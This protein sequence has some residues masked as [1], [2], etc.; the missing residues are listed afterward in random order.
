MKHLLVVGLLLCPSLLLAQADLTVSLPPGETALGDIGMYR[1]A[2]QSYDGQPVYMPDSWVGNFEPVAG[3]SY[4][5]GEKIMG[6]KALLLHSPWHIAPGRMWVDYRLKLPKLT[7]ITLT[8]SI[9][10]RAD[11]AVPGKSD[12]VTFGAYVGGQE[13]LHENY[14]AGQWKDYAFDMS[15]RAGETITLRL[16]VEPG[17][18]NNPSFDFSYFGDPKIICGAS[19]QAK[20]A[21]LQQL[22][23]TKAYRATADKSLLPLS[24]RPG[25]GVAPSNLL[26]CK[27]SVN[28]QGSGFDF[29]YE[30]ADGLIRYHY[31]PKTGTLDDFTCSVDG[32]AAFRPA[33]GGGVFGEIKEGERTSP[34]LL[35]GGKLLSSE[36]KANQLHV[37]W[38]YD[39]AGQPVPM[40]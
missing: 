39:V 27:N 33:S 6:R 4:L 21:L 22:T 30:G 19:S 17:P 28:K 2:Y 16:Q 23:A 20:Q 10:M 38:Q 36:L 25:Q 1:V 7:P 14:T 13:L 26:A 32:G 35:S 29:T 8:F 3:I 9:A 15:K 40:D 31:E 11:I 12:G 34:V 24:N 37:R 18:K 5:P